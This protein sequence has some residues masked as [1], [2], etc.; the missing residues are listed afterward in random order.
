M[1]GIES[2]GEDG[3]E[4]VRSD[5]GRDA[6]GWVANGPGSSYVITQPQKCHTGYNADAPMHMGDRDKKGGTV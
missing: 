2:D 3:M 6:F 4:D 1:T 5:T